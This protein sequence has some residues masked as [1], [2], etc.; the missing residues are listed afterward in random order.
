MKTKPIK[1]YRLCFIFLA[2]IVFALNNAHGFVH[3]QPA[4]K[5]SRIVP[6]IH[7]CCN[8]AD[9]NSSQE[10]TGNSSSQK[11]LTR[12]DNCGS[13]VDT[14]VSIN[15]IHAD[16]KTVTSN[17]A[18]AAV[19]AILNITA[20]CYGCSGQVICSERPTLANPSLMSIR[21]IVLLV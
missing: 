9:T 21:T 4:D 19:P 7:E 12:G 3:C 11:T 1:K 5:Q 17:I 8:V 16:K 15:V 13:C 20:A 10:I 6:I 18:V 14:I 2:S